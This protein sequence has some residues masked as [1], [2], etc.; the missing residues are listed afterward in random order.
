MDARLMMLYLLIYASALLLGC[1]MSFL[2]CA[3]DMARARKMCDC[4][5][6]YCSMHVLLPCT[7]ACRSMRTPWNTALL[8]Q[9]PQMPS[10]PAAGFRKCSVQPI[11]VTAVLTYSGA[12]AQDGSHCSEAP[13]TCFTD[14][15]RLKVHQAAAAAAV[16][17]LAAA[18]CAKWCSSRCAKRQQHLAA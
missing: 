9:C 2:M 16:A 4:A 8:L 17:T 15:A 5:C 3:H 11:K 13:R 6:M 1:G 14:Q 10:A 12:A 7:G 18:G